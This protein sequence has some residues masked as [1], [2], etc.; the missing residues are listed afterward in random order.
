ML[1]LLASTQRWKLLTNHICGVLGENN[2]LLIGSEL[3][4]NVCLLL[5]DLSKTLVRRIVCFILFFPHWTKG[6]SQLS[7]L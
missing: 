2:A 3:L 7:N 4:K 5:V 1:N 6:S